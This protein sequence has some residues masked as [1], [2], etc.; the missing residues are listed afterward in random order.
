MSSNRFEGQ[1][2]VVTGAG[3]G[4]GYAT[5]CQL[6]EEGAQVLALDVTFANGMPAGA[7]CVSVDVCS[8]ERL[9]EAARRV[10]D[11]IDGLAAFAGI[12]MGGRIDTL[13]I[14]GWQR[15]FDVNVLGTVRTIAAFL[16]ALRQKGGSIVLCSSQL[17][18]A[19]ARD[20]PAYA[21]SKGAINTL[22][23]SLALDHAAEGIRVNAI[24]PGATDTPMMTR[25]FRGK[26]GTAVEAAKQR[27]AMGRFGTARESAN[28][29]LF[30]MSGDATF[31]TGVV[32]PVDGGWCIA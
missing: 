29:A 15:V 16:P 11:G 24:A 7:E 27:H 13:N 23:R 22:C 6:C 14:V 10:P 21:A 19:G 1:T 17:S 31:T 2:F 32:F 3:S 5:T 12:E 18:I 4:I 9:A 28:A 26:P 30:L 25:S 8:E 20:C